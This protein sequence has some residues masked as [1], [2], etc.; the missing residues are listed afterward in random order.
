D[1]A[2]LFAAQDGAMLRIWRVDPRTGAATVVA[3]RGPAGS[4]E[5]ANPALRLTLDAVRSLAVDDAGNLYLGDASGEVRRIDAATREVVTIARNEG[6]ASFRLG[7]LLWVG[8]EA[9]DIADQTGH[10]W[11]VGAGDTRTMVAGGGPGF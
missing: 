7:G 3:G 1:G 4:P 11:R 6:P 10:I 8:P 2:V 9:L 5:G